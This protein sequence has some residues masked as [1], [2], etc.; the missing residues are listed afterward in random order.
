MRKHTPI[1]AS[2]KKKPKVFSIK[3]KNPK[4]NN[5]ASRGR[6]IIIPTAMDI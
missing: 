3:L 5:D 6:N 1:I 2:G 4:K